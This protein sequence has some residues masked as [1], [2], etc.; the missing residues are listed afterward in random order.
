MRKVFYDELNDTL[1]VV[2]IE[3][4]ELQG[5]LSIE[6]GLTVDLEEELKEITEDE[7]EKEEDVAEESIVSN[8][9]SKTRL[10]SVSIE[11]P[12]KRL[13]TCK[14][15]GKTGHFAKTCPG[16]VSNP[17]IDQMRKLVLQGLTDE[18]IYFEV[19]DS[20]TDAQFREYLEIAKSE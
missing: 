13:I 15:C 1:S 18:E 14:N 17:I 6:G 8:I 10:A 20:V 19:H 9:R 2:D 16:K 7:E 4:G 5:V 3:D 12:K 11:E